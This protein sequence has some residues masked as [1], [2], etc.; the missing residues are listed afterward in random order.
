MVISKKCFDYYEI[1]VNRPTI[2]PSDRKEYF[3]GDHDD[4]KAIE[5]MESTYYIYKYF[6]VDDS[7]ICGSCEHYRTRKKVQISTDTPLEEIEKYGN[8]FV[9]VGSQNIRSSV[10]IPKNLNREIDLNNAVYCLL[11]RIGRSRY[12]GEMTSGTCSINEFVKDPKLLHYHRNILIKCKLVTRQ[13]FQRKVKNKVFCGS[14][15]H[16][17]RFYNIVKDSAIVMVEKLFEFLSAK[18]NKL[19]ECDEIRKFLKISQKSL[20]KLVQSK[21]FEYIFELD[22]K[23]LF[24]KV[25]PDA[26]EEEYMFRSINAEKSVSSIR[27]LDPKLD[28]Y[29][30]WPQDDDVSTITDS[31]FLDCRR[32]RMNMGL[33]QQ[34]YEMVR[35]R[36]AEGATQFEIGKYFGLS[37]LNSRAVVRK[38]QRDYGVSHFMK[39]EGRQR[40][41]R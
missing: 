22:A 37:K 16:L 29:T 8:K 40:V 34:A 23:T 30:L 20:K 18:P 4:A 1:P 5:R 36:G 3:L 17:P 7:G 33:G 31:G 12:F 6:P 35:K 21:Q 24:R 27:L 39:D 28:I 32:Q 11:E 25:Y 26:T 15:L 14:L 19:A 41:S 38:I 13:T 9:V 10:L 2:F